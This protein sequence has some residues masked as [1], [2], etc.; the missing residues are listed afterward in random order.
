M[1]KSEK[2]THSAFSIAQTEGEKRRE[3][4]KSLVM[5]DM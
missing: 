1:F 3:G 4:G 5:S 2:E